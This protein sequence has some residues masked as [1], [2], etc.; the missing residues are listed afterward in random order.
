MIVDISRADHIYI[1][2]G[3]TDM[4]KEIDGLAT[5]VQQNFKLDVFSG[6]LLLSAASDVTE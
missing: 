3:F 6:S 2:Y 5:I 1:V 4:R